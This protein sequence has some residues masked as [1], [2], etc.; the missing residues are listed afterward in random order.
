MEIVEYIYLTPWN[1]RWWD[2]V[3]KIQSLGINKMRVNSL[4]AKE[5]RT[6]EEGH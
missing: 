3:N 5:K 4:L 1:N 6:D 2:I